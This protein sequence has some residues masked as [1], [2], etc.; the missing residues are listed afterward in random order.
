MIV[1]ISLP[2]LAVGQ[3]DLIPILGHINQ[4]EFGISKTPTIF[5]G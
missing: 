2:V 1:H 5:E 3:S 4:G